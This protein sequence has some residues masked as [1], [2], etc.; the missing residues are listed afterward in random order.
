MGRK[1]KGWSISP[2]KR[3]GIYTVRFTYAGEQV[4]RSTRRKDARQAQVEAARIYAETVSGRRAPTVGTNK[5]LELLFAEWLVDF[6][7][8]AADETVGFY[9]D[10]ASRT[11]LP[12]FQTVDALTTCGADDYR[13]H[14]LRQVGRGTVVRELTALR[15]F[16]AWASRKRSLTD[17]VE[18]RDPGR[19]VVGTPVLET[20]RVN[21]TADEVEALLRALPVRTRYGH[22]VR[23]L[24][25]TIWETSLR[26]G[27]MQRLS[28]PEHYRKGA[29][30]L[31]IGERID[32]ARY[33]R[34]IPLTPRARALLDDACPEKGLI[35]GEYDY[36]R[37]L[38]AA[39][40]KVGVEKERCK[41]LSAHDIRHAA[42]THAQE[43]SQNIAGAAY[44]AGH[45]RTATTAAYTHPNYAAGLEILG[46]RFGFLD[47]KL[48]TGRKPGDLKTQNPL[49]G[50]GRIELPTPTVSR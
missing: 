8:E 43:V 49:V 39:A 20:E 46:A 11:F 19:N 37:T 15:S 45:K 29:E 4:H 36:R 22:P 31:R 44:M 33:A 13:R 14:R 48:D 42:V 41:H 10:L 23:A 5:T 28:A 34:K 27:T 32:K 2:D 17:T 40:K 24:F 7:A 3:T 30:G 25:T 21:V 26:I 1:A 9:T 47:T 16:V 38:R 35:F 6:D 50:T 18:V 12:F